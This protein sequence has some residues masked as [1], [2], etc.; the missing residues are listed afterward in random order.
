MNYFVTGLLCSGKSTF[1]AAAR[2]HDFDTLNA[3][4][5][6]ANLYKDK[7]IIQKIQNEFDKYDL[8][9]NTEEVIK[10]LFFK[11]D[12]N[13][14]KIESIIHPEV[15]KIINEELV[16]KKNLIVEVPP[17]LS[18]YKLLKEN[19]SIFIDAD[20]KNR[21]IR[22]RKRDNKKEIDTFKRINN[23]QLDYIKLRMICDIIIDNN[24]IEC[25][26][27]YFELEIIKS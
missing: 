13:R 19:K 2:A 15:H 23:M 27:K 20:I 4:E 8:F 22:Y 1:L 6:V 5:L 17:L 7:T 16:N 25:F 11:S 24:G 14:K 12:A 21:I 10:I 3:D 18:N 26:N 9:R